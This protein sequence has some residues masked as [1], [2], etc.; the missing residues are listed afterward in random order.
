MKI[1]S[2]FLLLSLF[3]SSLSVKNAEKKALLSKLASLLEDKRETPQDYERYIANSNSNTTSYSG[4][5]SNQNQIDTLKK[6]NH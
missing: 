3:Y 2:I 6:K 4:I 5:I 1:I